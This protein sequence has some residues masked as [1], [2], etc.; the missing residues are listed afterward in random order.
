MRHE[1]GFRCGRVLAPFLSECRVRAACGCEAR[2]V[3]LAWVLQLPGLW[4]AD[5]EFPLQQLSADDVVPD[6]RRDRPAQDAGA[7]EC[8]L[9][10]DRARLVVASRGA[11]APYQ[12]QDRLAQTEAGQSAADRV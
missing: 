12:P 9:G 10:G 2:G 6:V 5:S 7:A 11:G 8:H 4:E 3:F 1:S